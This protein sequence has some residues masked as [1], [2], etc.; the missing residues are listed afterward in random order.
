MKKKLTTSLFILVYIAMFMLG[1]SGGACAE[2]TGSGSAVH[3]LIVEPD[4]GKA[5]VLDAIQKA[6]QSI[7]L[8]IY[9]VNDPDIL[10][11]LVSAAKRGVDIRII[12]NFYSFH[13]QKQQDILNT[14]KSLES[15]GIK[16][17]AANRI[18]TNTHEKTFVFDDNKAIIMTFNLQDSYFAT[19]RDFGII[20]VS[21]PEISEISKVFEA[22]WLY[23]DVTPSQE[24][25]VWSP[26][27]SRQKLI[28]L[29]RS[30][31]KTLEIYN[32]EAEDREILDELINAAQSGVKIRF[33]SAQ[34][35]G[36]DGKD[37]NV[38]GRKKLNENG[39]QAKYGD[40][41]YVHAK[42]ILV[43][44]GTP[45]SHAFVGSENFSYTSLNKNRELG[46]IIDEKEI[47]DRIHT[48]FE[49]DWLKAKYDESSENQ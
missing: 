17:K 43:D 13:E 5:A 35:M 45:D 27:N 23:Q 42:M 38:Y 34:L 7:K 4:D 49:A 24:S 19:T 14:M 2:Q 3:T 22:D 36:Y 6:K 32:E 10:S 39:V 15:Q 29:I 18:Y 48:I 11:G 40:A 16:T 21:A 9:E 20:T 28:E 31:K 33:I 41:L 47:L 46:A 25:L 44:Y 37:G 12:Y 26:V 30:A 1:I 8:T